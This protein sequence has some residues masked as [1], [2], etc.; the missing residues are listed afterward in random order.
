MLLLCTNYEA[1]RFIADDRALFVSSLGLVLDATAGL[2]GPRAKVRRP[3]LHTSASHRL[4]FFLSAFKRFVIIANDDTIESVHVE[5]S[6]GE[7]TVT[8]ASRVCHL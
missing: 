1:V 7:V 8:D 3:T 2:G 6:A 4:I 5:E